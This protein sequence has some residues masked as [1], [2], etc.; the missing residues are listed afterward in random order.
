MTKLAR[1]GLGTAQF[2]GKYGVSNC[3]GQPSE[4]EVAAILARAVEAG[5]GYLDTAAGYGNA[6]ALIGRHLP[7]RHALRI[8]TK[9]PP[10]PGDAISPEKA[11]AVIEALKRSLD[12]LRMPAVYGVLIH[13]AADVAKPGWQH[14]LASLHE[15][16]TRGLAARVGISVYDGQ[17]LALAEGRFSPD[18]VQLPCNVLDR[19]CISSGT[20]DRLRAAGIEV[21]ARSIFLQGL[22][23]MGPQALPEFFAPARA[24]IAAL[25]GRWAAAGLTPLAGCLGFVLSQAPIAA[26]LVG[27]NRC[28]ELDE[29]A[30][31]ACRVA[32]GA[33]DVGATALDASYLDPRRWPSF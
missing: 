19:R 33:C 18:I 15:V 24:S 27:I 26:V 1:I 30:A 8:V 6:E 20:L 25:H 22:L 16:R 5:F 11:R 9:L 3:H 7:T 10:I 2:G 12:R 31:A 14:L 23:L 4:A 13:R 29:I 17:E 28:A 21:H 32:E